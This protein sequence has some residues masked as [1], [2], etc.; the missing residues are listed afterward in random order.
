MLYYEHTMTKTVTTR[1]STAANNRSRVK[2]I[3][4]D[5]TVQKVIHILH[6]KKQ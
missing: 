3:A 5:S 4:H 1:T 6:N 2:Q